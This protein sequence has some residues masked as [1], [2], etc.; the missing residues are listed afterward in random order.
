MTSIRIRHEAAIDHVDFAAEHGA[1]FVDQIEPL[2]KRRR[3]SRFKR[4]EYVHIALRPEIIRQ[5][6]SEERELG[7]PPP[8]AEVRDAL[9]GDGNACDH[10]L[11]SLPLRPAAVPAVHVGH[12]LDH[13]AEGAVGEGAV[14]EGGHDVGG[15]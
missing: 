13:L 7:D 15:M 8:A 4:D 11:I 6:G 10:V 5:N 1:K 3:R 12:G 2:L 9:I 14:D